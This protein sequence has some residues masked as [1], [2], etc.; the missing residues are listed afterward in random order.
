MTMFEWSINFKIKATN[1]AYKT[2]EKRRRRRRRKYLMNVCNEKNALAN[3]ICYIQNSSRKERKETKLQKEDF[4]LKQI[5]DTWLD[6]ILK[7]KIFIL[8]EI[9]RF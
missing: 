1:K 3:F 4:V 5:K 6:L 9:I 7:N 8:L 2:L